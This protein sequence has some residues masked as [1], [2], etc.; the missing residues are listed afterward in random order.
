V[1][2]RLQQADTTSAT[3]ARVYADRKRGNELPTSAWIVSAADATDAMTSDRPYRR[4][5]ATP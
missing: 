3:T 4:I 2:S 1:P 5:T